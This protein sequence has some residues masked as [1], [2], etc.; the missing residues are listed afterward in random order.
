[1][2]N[3]RDGGESSLGGGAGGTGGGSGAG[4]MED[5]ST[6]YRK[7]LGDFEEYVKMMNDEHISSQ[8]ELF[9]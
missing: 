1:M 2:D 3:E 8:F 7:S 6:G 9:T 4:G 5:Y